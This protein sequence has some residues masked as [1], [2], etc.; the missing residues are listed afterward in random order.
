M[1]DTRRVIIFSLLSSAVPLVAFAMCEGRKV[2]HEISRRQQTSVAFQPHHILRTYIS[3][4][5]NVASSHCFIATAYPI[6]FLGRCPPKQ[7]GAQMPSSSRNKCEDAALHRQNTQP[8][9][10]PR[11]AFQ[12]PI[13]SKA[14]TGSM[15]TS[16]V[17]IQP[18]NP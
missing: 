18:C 14:L 7:G 13:R 10:Q 5:E 2:V 11:A 17:G 12:G 1:I 6:V 4:M 16:H 8:R 15:R 3:D 9:Y